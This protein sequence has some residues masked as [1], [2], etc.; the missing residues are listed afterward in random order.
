[1]CDDTQPATFFTHSDRLFRHTLPT[2]CCFWCCELFLHTWAFKKNLIYF[3]ERFITL[4]THCVTDLTSGRCVCSNDSTASAVCVYCFLFSFRP[5]LW[6][7]DRCC[8]KQSAGFTLWMLQCDLQLLHNWV[9]SSQDAKRV[10]S[11][12]SVSTMQLLGSCFRLCSSIK[13]TALTRLTSDLQN[14]HR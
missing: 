13:Q 11:S 4:H 8:I 14:N 12:E 9:Y 3:C 7:V 10:C 1:M 2:C 5:V 6:F